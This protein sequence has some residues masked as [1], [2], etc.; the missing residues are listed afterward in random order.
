[1]QCNN[2]GCVCNMKTKEIIDSIKD[3]AIKNDIHAI[4]F[5]DAKPFVG[6]ETQHLERQKTGVACSLEYRLS[7][8]ALINPKLTF[9]MAESFIVIL[10]P[11]HKYETALKEL[12][13]R[14][15]SGTASRDYHTIIKD[16]LNTLKLFLEDKH[17]ITGSIICDISP[18]S[19]RAIAV[20]AGLGIIRRNNMFYHEKL[21]SYVNIGSLVIDKKLIKSVNVNISMNPCKD[22]HICENRCPSQAILG[23][24]TINS[25]LCISF[26][27]QKKEITE[28]ESMVIG[29]MIYG[30]DVCQQVCPI[31]KMINNEQSTLIINEQINIKELLEIDNKTFNQT[32]K[33]TAA[34]WRGKRTLQRNAIAALG[35]TGNEKSLEVLEPYLEDQRPIIRAEVERSIRKLK[36]L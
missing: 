16:K 10:E 11:Y 5:C 15:A 29:K 13:G 18:L 28:K 14:M 24:G 22:C 3:F 7:I 30:C 2:K 12:H 6:L 33:E 25:N 27:T 17:N 35:N 32:F 34:G 1:M 8:E 26:L 21:G 19:D 23:D 31:N 9:A 4:G 20:R 36:K